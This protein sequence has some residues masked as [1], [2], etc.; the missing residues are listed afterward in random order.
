MS[1]LKLVPDL[2][3]SLEPSVDIDPEKLEEEI[4]AAAEEGSETDV[5]RVDWRLLGEFFGLKDPE[6]IKEAARLAE[7]VQK[8]VLTPEDVKKMAEL[9]GVDLAKLEEGAVLATELG[10]VAKAVQ[11]GKVDPETAKRAMSLTERALNF[12]PVRN[13][14]AWGLK[15]KAERL[16][17]E[18]TSKLSALKQVREA[19]DSLSQAEQ[20]E[21]LMSVL[22]PKVAFQ[23]A[24][25]DSLALKPLKYMNELTQWLKA[26]SVGLSKADLRP[27]DMLMLCSLGVFD[28]K[29]GED[30][31]AR[32]YTEL[33]ARQDVLSEKADWAGY[34][35]EKRIQLLSTLAKFGIS[36]DKIMKEV[37]DE[38]RLE[39]A[40][41][42][43]VEEERGKVHDSVADLG[44]L[45]VAA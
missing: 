13:A 10:Q 33:A 40:D 25:E 26:K 16:R 42:M 29:G 36:V 14:V 28:L 24:L 43:R 44:V 27:K 31:L 23:A 7:K 1:H 15:I 35:P 3:P 32:V 38:V 12:K 9:A 17:K 11:E 6:M 37:M 45:R 5:N 4:H 39:T 2:E 18:S 34:V 8:G 20:D 41:G 30:S 21:L 19:W 22:E